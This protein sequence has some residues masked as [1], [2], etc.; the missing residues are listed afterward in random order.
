MRSNHCTAKPKSN[1]TVN[2]I[3]KV[4]FIALPISLGKQQREGKSAGQNLGDKEPRRET[5]NQILILIFFG[6]AGLWCHAFP[7]HL[8][9]A[10]QFSICWER[11][12]DY[13]P[14]IR[15]FQGSFESLLV[16]VTT[17][18]LSVPDNHIMRLSGTEVPPSPH[19]ALWSG[20]QWNIFLRRWRGKIT[21]R[22]GGDPIR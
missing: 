17:W 6:P 13:L 18:A 8:W 7:A 4:G 15:T 12:A 5:Q 11:K 3:W 10:A 14:E 21:N 9:L 2:W 16:V 19:P 20:E 22:R 1:C